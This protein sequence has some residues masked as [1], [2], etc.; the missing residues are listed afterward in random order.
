MQKSPNFE[1]FF[2]KKIKI[3]IEELVKIITGNFNFLRVHQKFIFERFAILKLKE[4]L[5]LIQRQL[6]F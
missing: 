1:F 4:K 5:G 3:T 2:N 6:S